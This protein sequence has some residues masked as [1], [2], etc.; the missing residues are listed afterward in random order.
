MAH[1]VLRAINTVLLLTTFVPLCLAELRERDILN[2]FGLME[3]ASMEHFLND[4]LPDGWIFVE[5]TNFPHTAELDTSIRVQGQSSFKFSVTNAPPRSKW[6]MRCVVRVGRN[7]VKIGD[8]LRLRARVKVNVMHNARLRIA[9]SA[10]RVD[11]STIVSDERAIET[12]NTGWQLYEATITVPADTDRVSAGIVLDIFSNGTGSATFWVDDLT[13]TNGEMLAIPVK[14]QR[15]IRTFTYFSS[16]PDIYETARRYDIVIL[17]PYNWIHARPLKYYNPQ[18]QLYVYCNSVSTARNVPGWMDPLDY[19][20]VITQRP[21]WLLTDLQGNPISEPDYPD[22]LLVDIGNPELQQRWAARAAEIAKR[23]GFD[24]VFIDNVVYAYLAGITCRQYANAEEYTQAHT[25][26]LQTVVPLLRQQGLKVMMNFGYPWNEHPIYETWMQLADVVLAEGW[27][28][29][30]HRSSLFF[31][32]PVLQLRH[33]AALDAPHPV[34]V[35]AQ[36]RAS[37]EEEQARRYLLGCALLN[38]NQYTAFHISPVQYQPPPDYLPDYELAIGQPVE[39][40]QLIAGE[41]NS[42]G[43]FRRRFSN[44]I[45]LVNMHPDQSLS[46]SLDTDYVDVR[47]T[48]YHEGTVSLPPRSALI[49]AKPNT[50]LQV[51]VTPVGGS[52]RPPGEE[53]QFEVVV[54][55]TTS[56]PMHNLTVRVPVPETMQFVV[57]SASHG[58]IY[59]GVTRTVTWFIPTLS[60]SQSLSRT[61][62]ARVR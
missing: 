32:H 19:E 54:R 12:P 18:V 60:Q 62:R 25:R 55:N 30:K 28:R 39:T 23:C 46:A 11:G 17:T 8:Q 57:G 59:D 9:V 43:L 53:I 16:H 27:V 22:H 7:G 24:G 41:R 50:R 58:G 34:I 61:F 33:I 56:S 47:G 6:N 52:S 3:H 15:N 10:S 5:R 49:L 38:A 36:G 26:F 45:V 40:Y 1:H 2:T 51:T 44:G 21:E 37:A 29:V 20:Y 42:G 14:A 31:L 48:V 4:K 35:A 13:V